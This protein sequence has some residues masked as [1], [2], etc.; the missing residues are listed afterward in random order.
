MFKLKAQ[1]L[2]ADWLVQNPVPE[3]EKLKF[4]NK[5]IKLWDNE[6]GVSLK[7]PNKRYSIKREDL[8]IRLRDYLVR[9]FFIEKYG[10]D[11]PII[12]GAQ[13]PLHRSETAQGKSM[14][15]K[16]ENTFAKENHKLSR[17]R[18]TVFTLVT[19]VSNIN[20]QPKF[21]FKGKGVR[22]KVAVNNVNY[23]RPPSGSYRL[24]HMIKTINNLPNC[25]N[26]FTQKNF[27]I[28]VLDDYAVHLMPEVRKA[29]YEQGYILVVMDGGITGFVQANDTDLY[30]SL[31]V[32]HRHKEM[33]LMLKMLEKDKNKVPSPNHVDMVKMLLSAWKDVPNPNNFAEVFKELFVTNAL[34]GSKDCLVSNF[35]P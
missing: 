25:F 4:S 15:F 30:R 24:E 2:Y 11:P 26:P 14:S 23:Q 3:N 18:V 33:D 17:E 29:L 19:S 8:L 10:V 6:Y 32:L 7:R 22:A 28:Y 13:M 35:L 27:A 31:K 12:N 9:R 5:L 34:D 21:I 16:G 1:Q 20:L